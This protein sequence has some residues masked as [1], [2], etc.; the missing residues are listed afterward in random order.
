MASVAAHPSPVAPAPYTDRI[1]PRHYRRLGLAVPAHLLCPLLLVLAC[2]AEPRGV[3]IDPARSRG[4]AEAAVTIVEFA[5]YQCPYC[6]RAQ[7]V[8]DRLM[9]EFKGKLRL[10]YKDLPAPS[11]AGARP[12][13]EAARC[14][15]A[16][17][18]FWEY[19]D[20]LFLASP[21]FSRDH[22]IRYAERLALDRAA[23]AA[24]LD[25]RQFREQVDVDVREARA[26][27]I[28]ETPTFLINGKPLV[29]ALPIEAFREAITEALREAGAR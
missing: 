13:A 8:L 26:L 3:T 18:V 28:R 27:G 12:A 22:L 19:H 10:V 20:L 6:K 25:T 29:G 4:P 15:A 23:F 14:A 7:S 16:R 9:Q 21:D 2:S 24:C 5:D 11:H 17:G 1:M